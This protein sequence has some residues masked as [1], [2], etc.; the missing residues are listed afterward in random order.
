MATRCGRCGNLLDI[1][2]SNQVA[3]Y[4]SGACRQAAYRARKTAVPAEMRRRNRWVSWKPVAR[5]GR[6]TKMPVQTNGRAASST[7]PATW[8]AYEKV[9][10]L[11]RRGFALGEG[12]GCIDLDHCLIEGRPTRAAQEFLARMPKTYIEVSP[13]GDGLHI[14]GLLPEAAGSRRVVDGLSVE[15]YSTGRYMTV[16]GSAF[17]GS[18]A[19]LADL[20]GLH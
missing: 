12:I 7:D 18:V 13:S 15:V 1:Q 19:A 2:R 3:R 8:T 14:F 4:C 10:N 6:T 17:A 5:E 20:R 16:T 11:P 9:K